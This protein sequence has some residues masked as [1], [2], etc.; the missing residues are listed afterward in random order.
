MEYEP[1]GPFIISMLELKLDATI[2][3]EWQKHSQSSSDVPQYRD[4]LSFI[5]LRAQ[6]SKTSISD[7]SKK[8]LRG[9]TQFTKKSSPVD[10]ASFAASA[11]DS[12]TGHCV[13]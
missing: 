2:L 12:A 11:T 5:N 4:R 6:A 13:L 7:H 9:D 8:P 10:V 3:F 1:S